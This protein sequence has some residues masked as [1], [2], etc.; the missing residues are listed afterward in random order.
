MIIVLGINTRKTMNHSSMKENF[1]EKKTREPIFMTIIETK[2]SYLKEKKF[3]F[4]TSK[5]FHY[6]VTIVNEIML[7]DSLP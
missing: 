1:A 5:P 6:R 7:F 4:D 2:L 3:A